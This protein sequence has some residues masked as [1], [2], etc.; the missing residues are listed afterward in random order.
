MGLIVKRGRPRKSED[1]AGTTATMLHRAR[2]VSLD[3]RLETPF[4]ALAFMR[5][6]TDFQ[7]DAAD[8]IAKIYRDFDS[9]IGKK[10]WAV[11][12]SFEVGNGLSPLHEDA[13]DR[14]RGELAKRD[15]LRLHGVFSRFSPRAI[16]AVEELCIQ[17]RACP[18]GY[19]H[20]VKAVLDAAA[21]AF[22]YKIRK[23]RLDKSIRVLD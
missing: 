20:Q 13:T 2:S 23:K 12:P 19:L 15:F 10:R 16:D 14:E 7:I 21:D 8:R 1:Q 11:S 9:Q 6:F 17:G 4:G 22:G 3:P 5:E 18:P